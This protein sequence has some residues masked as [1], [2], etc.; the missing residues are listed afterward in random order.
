[1]TFSFCSCESIAKD[2]NSRATTVFNDQSS[3]KFH[4]ARIFETLTRFNIWTFQS[5]LRAIPSKFSRLWLSPIESISLFI[6]SRV[7]LS[8]LWANRHDS[9]LAIPRPLT[10]RVLDLCRLC[11]GCYHLLQTQRTLNFRV[12]HF[13]LLVSSTVVSCKRTIKRNLKTFEN[14]SLEGILDILNEDFR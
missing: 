10:V 5:H 6:S 12:S 1:M 7:S 2:F 11:R 4:A 14:S 9:C 13:L 3:P 8:F